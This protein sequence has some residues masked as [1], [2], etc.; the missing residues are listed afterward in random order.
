LQDRIISVLDKPLPLLKSG[1]YYGPALR[2]MAA[3][4]NADNDKTVATLFMLN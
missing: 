3:S 1:D 2:K 4:V